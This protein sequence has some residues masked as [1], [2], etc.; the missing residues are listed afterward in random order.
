MSSNP[1]IP[2]PLP[3]H[4][5]PA[6]ARLLVD[7]RVDHAI[8]GVLGGHGWKRDDMED[9]VGEVRVRVLSALARGAEA[10]RDVDAMKAFATKVGRDFAVDGLRKQRTAWKY[11]DGPT[12]EADKHSAPELEFETRDPVDARRALDA[13]VALFREGKM[14][15]KGVEIL[16]GVADC[17]TYGEIAEQLSISDRAVQGRLK[18]MRRAVQRRL[19]GGKASGSAAE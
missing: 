3:P 2:A 16:Q 5:D 12:D 17:G 8:R 13:T 19:S 9:G 7:P 10:P 4:R 1:S 11:T 18:T 14:P 15:D 6:V